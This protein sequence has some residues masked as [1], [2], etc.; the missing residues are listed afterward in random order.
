MELIDVTERY[1]N[2]FP[3]GGR[4]YQ[5]SE[6]GTLLRSGQPHS[7]LKPHPHQSLDALV[8]VEPAVAE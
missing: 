6:C 4:V 3:A 5:C 1:G 2:Q 7:A 8:V